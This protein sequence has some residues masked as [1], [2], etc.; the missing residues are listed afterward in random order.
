MFSYDFTMA[1]NKHSFF[2]F[3][4]CYSKQYTTKEILTYE[5]AEELKTILLSIHIHCHLDLTDEWC[6]I[7]TVIKH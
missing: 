1:W 2:F 4:L 5:C 6:S 3:F 7:N